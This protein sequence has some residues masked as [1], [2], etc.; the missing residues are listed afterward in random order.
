MEPLGWEEIMNLEE[1]KKYA[2]LIVRVGANVQPGQYVV[3][4]TD[5]SQESFAS[6]VSEKCYEAGAKRVFVHWTSSLFDQVDY[7]MAQ[8]DVLKKVPPFEEACHQFMAK[9]LPVLIWID[10]DDPDGM[11]GADASKIAAVRSAKFKVLGKYREA[12]NNKAQW[13]IAGAPSAAWARKVFP[14]ISDEEAIERL[15]Y[16]ILL[17]ARMKEGDGIE[18][19]KAHEKELKARCAYLNALRLK[20]LHYRSETGTDLKVGLIPGVLFQGGG[21]K[22]LSG[23]LYQPNIPSEEVFTS[24]KRGEAEGVVFASKPLVYNGQIINDFHIRFKEGR[25]VEVHAKEGEAALQSIL[26]LDEGA[27]YL[28]EGALIPYHSPIND[29]GI[30]FYNTLYDENAAC[31]LAL[32]HGFE[33]LYPGFEKMTL[34]EVHEAGINDS[35]GHVDFMIGDPYLDITG[36][37]ENGEKV[38]LFVKGEWAF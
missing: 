6:L 15:W 23:T 4:R 14:G 13:C 28:G 11:K 29:T 19:W 34:K 1:K 9:E 36:E 38:P 37:M 7:R 12:Q 3:I 22:T 35:L 26:T 30:L 25:A 10:A 8:M 21:E 32:G 27:S 2:E 16:A 33:E 24:P 18:N 17:T 31:H 20:S 5:V